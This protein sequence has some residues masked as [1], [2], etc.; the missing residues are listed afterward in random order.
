MLAAAALLAAW[1]FGRGW[2]MKTNN[3][4]ILVAVIVVVAG[5]AWFRSSREGSNVGLPTP[6]ASPSVASPGPGPA[7]V[8][9]KEGALCPE[10]PPTANGG[11]TPTTGPGV[12]A[13]NPA[14]AKK[15]PRV[16]DL[17]ADK[18][19][20]CKELAPILEQLRKEYAGRVTVDFIDV[21]KNPKAG[22]PYKTR[23]IPTQIFF[24]A[25]GK[26]FWRHE[27][28]LPKADF[29]AKFAELGVK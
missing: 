15:L 1:M 4:L 16:V 9:A 14:V 3:A 17:G 10:P 24:D 18:C 23:V 26:E 21:W 25:N 8:P 28:F 22:E 12:P 6:A 7:T 13:T 19:K 20:A 2:K 29:I 11:D 5:V 27:G